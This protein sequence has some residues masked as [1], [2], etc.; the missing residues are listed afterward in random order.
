MK[1]IRIINYGCGNI[2][3]LV[4]AIEFLG[5]EAD[6]T[7]DKKKIINSSHLILPG[8]GAFGHAIDNLDKYDLKKT[9]IDYAKL[10][11][12]LLCICLG[13]QL[14]F[15]RSYEF[16]SHKGLG[17]IEGEVIKIPKKDQKD[18]KIPHMGWNEIY[19][20]NNE[21]KWKNKILKN[22]TP[23]KS[24]YFVHS[25]IGIT[26]NSESTL[27]QCNYSGVSIPAVVSIDNIFGCQFH[28]EKSGDDGLQILKNFCEI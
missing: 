23:G 6:V 17:L 15:D 22:V 25:F 19:P 27:A 16:G 21:K 10:N 1:K 18:L 14:L 13:M 20:L 8:V 11:K 7:N 26:K 12:P 4:R 9:I 24:F 5:Y 2:F 3:N 28:P